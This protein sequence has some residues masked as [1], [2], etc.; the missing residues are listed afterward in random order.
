MAGWN[1]FQRS[2]K[3]SG[4]K[5]RD[6]IEGSE[7]RREESQRLATTGNPKK[8]AENMHETSCLKGT[9]KKKNH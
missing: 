2:R 9:K 3:E 5:G 1:T 8:R 6:I 7:T 4:G